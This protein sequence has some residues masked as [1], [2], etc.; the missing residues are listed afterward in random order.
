M[1]PRQVGLGGIKRTVPMKFITAHLPCSTFS[2]SLRVY[3][4]FEM[5]EAFEICD[6]PGGVG[7]WGNGCR[8][9]KTVE[10]EAEEKQ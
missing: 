9:P 7:E 6:Q 1:S 5:K 8:M 3:M 2:P 10:G 4:K